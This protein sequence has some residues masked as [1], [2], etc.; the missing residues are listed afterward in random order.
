MIKEY[1]DNLSINYIG[2]NRKDAIEK[3][4]ENFLKNLKHKVKFKIIKLSVGPKNKFLWIF[5]IFFNFFRLIKFY[6]EKRII[7]FEEPKHMELFVNLLFSYKKSMLTVHHLENK[8]SILNWFFLKE[9][10]K[11]CSFSR[12]IAISDKTKRDLIE[13][14]NRQK[15]IQTN[16]QEN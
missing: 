5:I 16:K 13:Q 9:K 2:W 11:H 8:N 4:S 3:V 6:F 1:K 15:D 10:L 14:Y 12:L 7:H